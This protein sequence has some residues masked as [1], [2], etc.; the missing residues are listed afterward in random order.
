MRTSYQI[1][2]TYPLDSP[3][4]LWRN[5]PPRWYIFETKPQSELVASSWLLRHG[6]LEAWYPTREYVKR[7]RNNKTATSLKPEWPR[8][9]F[10]LCPAAPTSW[11]NL[12]DRSLLRINRVVCNG[13]EPVIL[14]AEA[15]LNMK[16]VPACLEAIR[17]ARA[18]EATIRPGDK[19]E[20][21]GGEMHGWQVE[22]SDLDAGFAQF[23]IPLLG[24]SKMKAPLTA[25]RKVK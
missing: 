20:I 18:E 11:R 1:G 23:V 14:D 8:Y 17:K 10:A 9:M 22:V 6:A 4:P 13:G 3:M 2:E 21:Q 15:L 16:D 24:G 7:L 25:L 12:F 19:V 5:G